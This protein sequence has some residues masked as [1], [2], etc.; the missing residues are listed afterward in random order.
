MRMASPAEPPCD[1]HGKPRGTS[2][3]TPRSA[4]CQVRQHA[5][6]DRSLVN[7][8]TTACGTTASYE[9]V[10]A[11]TLFEYAD[12]APLFRLLSDR[13]WQC[14]FALNMVKR[15]VEELQDPAYRDL[16]RGLWLAR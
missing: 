15:D 7:N 3:N 13:F 10:A 8:S 4:R 2:R 11:F 16:Q 12:E 14:V 6:A 5:E 9:I 1:L